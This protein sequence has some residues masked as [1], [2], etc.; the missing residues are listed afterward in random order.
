MQQRRQIPL[1][2]QEVLDQLCIT[3]YYK[4]FL[5]DT[6]KLMKQNEKL[7]MLL[8]SAKSTDDNL[9]SVECADENTQ[10]PLTLVPQSILKNALENSSRLPKGRRHPEILKKIAV[11][12]FIYAGPSVYEFIHSTL[13]EALPSLSTV[14]H[15]VHNDYCSIGEGEFR[16]DSLLKYLEDNSVSKVFSVGEDAT[17]VISRRGV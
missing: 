11:S 9:P 4:L 2:C 12:L 15:I 1:I 5:N 3:D 14:K 16:F 8:Q 17:R 13:A 6:E 7:C 10:P